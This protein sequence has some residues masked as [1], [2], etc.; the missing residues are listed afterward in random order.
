MLTVARAR[1]SLLFP[2]P[3]KLPGWLGSTFRGGLGQHLR[4]LVCY[5]PGEEC[6][7]CKLSDECP[8]YI[9]FMRPFAKRGRAPPPRPI[10]VIPPFG[11]PV[12]G[13]GRMEVDLVL[14][15]DYIRFFPH[16]ILTLQW[17]GMDG[18][19]DLRRLG[20]NRFRITEG[21]CW[22]SG[23]KV[24]GDGVI[25]VRNLRAVEVRELEPFRGD[26]VRVEF[27]VPI[28]L[29][30][31]IPPS[32]S[33]FLELV[34]H[35]LILLVNEYGDG[36]KVPDFSCEGSGRVIESRPVK[37]PGRSMRS[38]RREF[39]GW[40]GAAEYHFQKIDEVGRWLL[41]VGRVLGAGSKFSFGMGFFELG[42]PITNSIS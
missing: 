34:R 19:G 35:R 28:E 21:R 5:R 13:R 1:L 4:P 42:Q 7:G 2:G 25:Y 37:L 33:D 20:F 31:G 32:P 27:K 26:E 30:K 14:V 11:R 6:E 3:A 23:E 9:G 12:E 10:A 22:F 40:V 24:F 41:S 38:G 39:W 17:L 16:L 8:F 15:G 18:L 29:P 36:G